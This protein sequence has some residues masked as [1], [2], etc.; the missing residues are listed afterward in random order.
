ME[1]STMERLLPVD[2]LLEIA[3][4]SDDAATIV[5][6][7]AASKP[8]RR[9]ILD[10]A[11]PRRL[12]NIAATKG[13]C[14]P[15]LATASYRIETYFLAPCTIGT[16]QPALIRRFETS[17]L[18]SFQPACSR[19]GLLVLADPI[20]FSFRVCNT[21]TGRLTHVSPPDSDRGMRRS[22]CPAL[23]T[24]V[25]GAGRS[26]QFELLVLHSDWRA[27]TFSSR[28]DTWGAAR[29]VKPPLGRRAPPLTTSDAYLVAPVVTGRTVHWL[30]N[31]G[32]RFADEEEIIILSL[33]VDTAQAS[34][35]KQL[36][37][38]YCR[39]SRNPFRSLI[40]T[41]TADGR[42]GVVL[43][44]HLGI[45]MWT[46]TAPEEGSTRS[47]ASWSLHLVIDRQLTAALLPHMD[48]RFEWFGERTGT[49]L[50]VMGRAGLVQIDLRTKEA[51]VLH[52][53][54]P[55]VIAC[56]CLH[57][58]DVVSFLDEMRETPR[59]RYL[60]SRYGRYFPDRLFMPV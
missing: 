8:L 57:E 36:P 23:I 41:A 17:L 29:G 43:A 44:G 38:N 26:V 59:R 3:A 46:L 35:I 1:A 54:T 4:R 14:V 39:S 19:D 45:T 21:F 13:R 10:P 52:G 33:H 37:K 15:S 30:C 49:V 47:S 48:V 11:F 27:Q 5:R 58:I 42:L 2:V 20:G 56:A 53:T 60:P 6:L 51:I 34:V 31:A 9:G 16:S 22:Y 50:L 24:A 18:L 28:V 40:L 25:D 7:A 55:R 32:H 12:A